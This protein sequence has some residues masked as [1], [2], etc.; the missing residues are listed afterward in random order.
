MKMEYF[1]ERFVSERVEDDHLNNGTREEEQEERER[2]EAGGRE[3]SRE[4]KRRKQHKR[5]AVTGIKWNIFHA[6]LH[7]LCLRLHLSL[8]SFPL[9]CLLFFPPLGHLCLSLCSLTCSLL[10]LTS[11]VIPF[12]SPSSFPSVQFSFF[13]TLLCLSF[14]SFPLSAS[15]SFLFSFSF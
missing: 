6:V 3:G 14:V 11:F 8:P 15:P 13:L 12:S 10:S 1:D 5:K 2:P 7:A 9:S 4:R